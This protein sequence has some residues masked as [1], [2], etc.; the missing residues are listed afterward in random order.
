MSLA[1]LVV[2]R[3]DLF[4]D[5]AVQLNW[6][7]SDRKKADKAAEHFVF[8]GPQYHGVSEMDRRSNRGLMDTATFIAQVIDHLDF[9]D[10][11]NPFLLAVAGYGTGKSHLAVT[12]AALLD[13]P[14]SSTAKVIRDNIQLADMDIGQDMKKRMNGNMSPYI[15]ITLN[16]MQDFN[17]E[18]EI[19]RQIYMT[20][21]RERLDATPLE[22]L[23]PRFKIAIKFCENYYNNHEADFKKLFGSK[24]SA[25][26]V[27]KQLEDLNE[28]AFKKVNEVYAKGMGSSIPVKDA[29]D[30]G[31]FLKV[32]KDNYC[33][34]KKPF[35]GILIVFDEFGRY[36]EFS[37][38][39]PQVAGS[40]S[41]QKLFEAVQN[42]RDGVFLVG[43]IQYEI[44][45]YVARIVPELRVELERYV[46]R[47]NTAQTVR[48]ST[49]L[50]TLLAHLLEKK[51]LDLLRNHQASALESP[52]ALQ[53][54]MKSW[55]PEMRNHS[56]WDEEEAFARVIYE[57][58]W[59]LH[60][61]A[62]W[63]L[64][65][66]A[67]IGRL[68]QQRSALSFVADAYNRFKNRRADYDI[69]IWAVDLCNDAMVDEFL[70]SEEYV[71]DIA[72]KYEGALSRYEAE[73][74]SEHKRVL[75]GVLLTSKIGIRAN[76]ED[77]ERMVAL[78]SGLD[79]DI[80]AEAIHHLE[81]E[82]GVLEY[83]VQLSQYEIVG[84]AVSRKIFIEFL[85]NKTKKIAQ[86]KR[87]D[88]FAQK[89]PDWNV[90][91][92]LKLFNISYGNSNDIATRDWDYQLNYSN[93]STLKNQVDSMVKQWRDVKKIDDEKGIL[94]YCYVGPL[95]S[96]ELVESTTEAVINDVYLKQ[97]ITEGCPLAIL[98]LYDKDGSFGDYMAQYMVLEQLSDEEFQKFGNFV[99][100]ERKHLDKVIQDT[101]VKLVANRTTVFGGEQQI[102]GARLGEQLTNLFENIYTK[103]IPFPFDGFSSQRGN[104]GPDCKEFTKDLFLGNL[105][106][107][108]IAQYTPSQRNRAVSVIEQ[109]WGAIDLDGSVRQMP[110]N[111]NIAEIFTE[112]DAI[113]G[114]KQK[115]NIGGQL[116][117]ICKPPY[118][119]NIASAG[120]LL[121]LFIGSR[122]STIN[123][124]ESKKKTS[125]E[126]W[127]SI[128]FQNN[129]LSMS[130]LDNT[131]IVLVSEQNVL[132][133]K[134]A[135]EEWENQA[136]YT[137]KI[138]YYENNIRALEKNVEIPQDLYFRYKFM[139]GQNE[140]AAARISE[141]DSKLKNAHKFINVG[142]SKRDARYTVKAAFKFKEIM[143]EMDNND[144][145]DKKQV[146]QIDEFYNHTLREHIPALFPQWLDGLR[147]ESIEDAALFRKEMQNAMKDL[148][149]LGLQEECAL[150]EKHTEELITGLR[151]K[152]EWAKLK[153]SVSDML[154]NQKITD[155]TSIITLEN[156]IRQ[157][158]D[159]HEKI[160]NMTGGNPAASAQ[161]GLKK[162]VDEFIMDCYNRIKA[163]QKR[164][165]DLSKIDT[166]KSFKELDYMANESA[167]LMTLFDH[168]QRE[169]AEL[170]A[171]RSEVEVIKGHYLQLEDMNL[172]SNS[173]EKAYARCLSEVQ[174]LVEEPPLINTDDIYSSVRKAILQKREGM[175][176]VWM[177]NE[178]PDIKHIKEYDA[179][180]VMKLIGALKNPPR[181]LS[182]EQLSKVNAAL[183][184]AEERASEI[185][186][187]TI[188]LSFNS[189]SS[190]NKKRFLVKIYDFLKANLSELKSS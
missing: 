135:L 22:A 100:G 177:Y 130:V 166:C 34:P 179:A 123:M 58:C 85:R 174:A 74:K 77:Y 10:D 126:D 49:N 15:V 176:S 39:K 92:K 90:N 144:V 26:L 78:F 80:T 14:H 181:L 65:K 190:E 109:A 28:E 2:F 53:L 147:I 164:L 163:A 48:L 60:P 101:F 121:A 115:M 173:F 50:E 124:Y 66:L 168:K 98:L 71:Q 140:V 51:D 172:D 139:E 159:Y 4:F 113:L 73:F 185:E 128:A 96:I 55:L 86:S 156:W 108:R 87:A 165:N 131:E 43:F 40:G 12:L 37:V 117:R 119:C 27:I 95:S 31:K 170:E 142:Q 18:N 89:M 70:N 11:S 141:W 122:K 178:V 20:L 36:L 150:L 61:T 33:G 129:F 154:K 132:V 84:D 54:T 161:G 175:A 68:L 44:Q 153:A 9:K 143:K 99:D 105:D 167:V 52:N 7:E 134:R 138:S 125:I 102:G 3:E 188:L 91:W 38:H 110:R 69:R 1:E 112:L 35:A 160:K 133:W 23:R 42:N 158:G 104:G 186:V 149:N 13:Q 63:L 127:L 152:D 83:N 8:H 146:A 24:C 82:Y 97:K 106:R 46:D 111:K 76:K 75:K 19:I 184:K 56:I 103:V 30:L 107:E 47:F 182:E 5:G 41:L 67:S 93:P 151:F 32:T 180:N 157:A 6:F 189:M 79:F 120:M 57:G 94:L 148:V 45:A 137:G 162:A 29:E 64:Y 136:T 116:R 72:Y 16:G 25:K 169:S 17:L 21:Q 81:N 59:P 118:G 88:L 183:K 62:T 114:S 155:S 145:W 187:D 171:I